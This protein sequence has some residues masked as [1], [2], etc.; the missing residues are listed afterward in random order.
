[1]SDAKDRSTGKP[2]PVRE[3]YAQDAMMDDLGL[4]RVE[5]LATD[6][7][8]RDRHPPP[9]PQ[10][11]T[12]QRSHTPR[13]TQVAAAAQSF[14]DAIKDG[15][16]HD[17]DYQAV[18][19]LDTIADGNLHRENRARG[20]NGQSSSKAGFRPD[21][22]PRSVR[23]PVPTY[24]PEFPTYHGRPKGPKRLGQNSGPRAS[25]S[26]GNVPNK[27]NNKPG[28]RVSSLGGIVPDGVPVKLWEPTKKV[29]APKRTEFKRA[30]D[31]PGS[32]PPTTRPPVQPQA[33]RASGSGARQ[34]PQDDGAP[35]RPNHNRLY[36]H[37][38]KGQP[39]KEA[40]K[41]PDA[42]Q[43]DT[44]PVLQPK[45]IATVTN[46]HRKDQ[47]V[48]T[49]APAK[50][51]QRATPLQVGPSTTALEAREVFFQHSVRVRK[52]VDNKMVFIPGKTSIYGVA[53]QSVAVWELIMDQEEVIRED[54]RKL[55]GCFRTL[56]T[57][58]IRCRDG[59]KGPIEAYDL[60]FETS[61]GAEELI[62]VINDQTKFW[63]QS[64]LPKS[65]HSKV[66]PEERLQNQ[67]QKPQEKPPAYIEEHYIEEQGSVTSEDLM[68]FEESSS[69]QPLTDT[70]I[71]LSDV[72]ET[73]A[74]TK[75]SV[76]TNSYLDALRDIV[77][78]PHAPEGE[79][80]RETSKETPTFLG[81]S[82]AVG[83]GFELII[84]P[85]NEEAATGVEAEIKGLSG[86][87]FAALGL[88]GDARF[89][90]SPHGDNPSKQQRVHDEE[91]ET[92][93]FNMEATGFDHLSKHIS[94]D[95][96]KF[97][98][99]LSKEAYDDMI[100]MVTSSMQCSDESTD[101]LLEQARRISCPAFLIIWTH[102]GRYDEYKRLTSDDQ[103]L[104]QSVVYA[105]VLHGHGRIVRS[106]RSMKTL[107]GLQ[108]PCPDEIQELNA[109][110]RSGN[111]LQDRQNYAPSRS[112]QGSP[113]PSSLKRDG[114]HMGWQN[115]ASRS[116]SQGPPNS[117]ALTQDNIHTDQ[118]LESEVTTQAKSSKVA[119]A[120]DPAR[121]VDDPT[122]NKNIK[123]PEEDQVKATSGWNNV[124]TDENK[125]KP[126][127]GWDDFFADD[128]GTIEPKTYSTSRPT[129]SREIVT[130][131]R[132]EPPRTL[133]NSQWATPSR[134]QDSPSTSFGLDRTF[135][136]RSD[137]TP[138]SNQAPKS[139][140]HIRTNTETTNKSDMSALANQMGSTQSH[141]S[142]A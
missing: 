51:I 112:S 88:P 15:L 20:H 6:E 107:R 53:E 83:S 32:G 141:C 60:V 102:L 52:V 111:D 117:L 14:N 103:K 113:N 69:P 138:E 45:H 133:S 26:G 38:M 25:A 9:R 121:Q 136:S 124:G 108:Q 77:M 120:H 80:P 31:M 49:V 99:G 123:A 43:S 115:F 3:A 130:N 39:F 84:Q 72:P 101:S 24:D 134:Q 97:L 114:F 13:S 62:K 66:Q 78:L 74:T 126:A 122:S 118:P 73:T 2:L 47:K 75:P 82:D 48:K 128:D 140:S 63:A 106:P 64:P 90:S 50:G 109:L 86:T 28:T 10:P 135:S 4:G 57:S 68:C 42:F 85:T 127:S 65:E 81:S 8:R 54:I 19:N 5:E 16:F 93:F 22:L 44:A 139:S 96:L 55:T 33:G 40:T 79:A 98:Y 1:M 129:G 35:D 18:Q 100:Q 94:Q 91:I 105:A 30:N 125:A 34:H 142:Q 21:E 46:G 70:L 23:R 58:T 76:M 11:S 56:T 92:A 12:T 110:V 29:A 17:D 41:S 119:Q 131:D 116:S 61:E 27:N 71:D 95:A 7:Q 87:E 67:P 36:N 37:L 137:A 132:S 104:V 89:P 59:P